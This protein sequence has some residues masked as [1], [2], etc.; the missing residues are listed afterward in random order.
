MKV[1]GENPTGFL[2]AQNLHFTDWL[3][4][5]KTARLEPEFV[6]FVNWESF[7][8]A[9]LES[10]RHFDGEV[11]EHSGILT[12]PIT[13]QRFRPGERAPFILYEGRPYYFVSDSTRA[14][15]TAMPAMY[16]KPSYEM[17]PPEAVGLPPEPKIDSGNVL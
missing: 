6:S 16:A 15:F 14:I 17:L 8:F 1:F 5:S 9:D 10:K 7:Y 13:H 2:I 3:D 11:L 4:S 12:D